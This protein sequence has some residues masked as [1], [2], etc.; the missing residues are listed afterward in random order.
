LALL[1]N[2]RGEIPLHN[3]AR[4]GWLDVV[5][6]FL[7]HVPHAASISTKQGSVALHVAVR[8]GHVLVCRSLL[9]TYPLGASMHDVDGKLPLH[10]CAQCGYLNVAFNLIFVN[11]DAIRIL[12]WEGN[13]PL[14][15]AVQERQ[16]EMARYL[17]EL[18]PLALCT[19]NLR[20]EIPLFP[21]VRSGS[22]EV[23]ALL[24]QAWPVGC[25]C[26]LQNITVDDN[27]N[28]GW[29][30]WDILLL[31]LRGSVQNLNGCTLL[32]RTK[33][34]R[35]ILETSSNWR[36]V[37]RP[38]IPSCLG[39]QQPTHGTT[40]SQ[41]HLR[42][43]SKVNDTR[44][45]EH[46]AIVTKQL[47]QKATREP[48]LDL[49]IEEIVTSS[50]MRSKSPILSDQSDELPWYTS[51]DTRKRSSGAM[52]SS[53]LGI[54]KH[55]A[56]FP[57]TSK[58]C[59]LVFEEQKKFMPLHAALECSAS[60]HV[61]EYV[62]KNQSMQDIKSL[63]ERGMLPLHWAV[64]QCNRPQLDTP[65]ERTALV[66]MIVKKLIVK[67]EDG[68]FNAAMIRDNIYHRLPLH[69]ALCYHADRRVITAL[70]DAYPSSATDICQT[71]DVFCNKTP[72]HIAINCDCELDI[73]Y[74]LLKRDPTFLVKES[75]W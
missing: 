17:L 71:R 58:T 59:S 23:V 29:I 10:I 32:G 47:M 3:A 62:L 65:Q 69:F 67:S 61:I 25:R 49:E 51:S 9:R 43:K 56:E 64:M 33:P 55:S 19:V 4:E 48:D 41:H 45:V 46:D 44:K 70:I 72:L 60:C 5:E 21:A 50:L 20:N 6:Y 15:D 28:S 26:L 42:K 66:D 30:S 1:P 63:D 22:L 34:P 7:C 2:C 37:V 18:Y 73:I 13:L 39:L 12:D 14:H 75:G 38:S 31:L 27:I 11:P 74:M 53:L 24:V 8:E 36:R 68:T 40:D 52:V 54:S 16:L 57:T 35:L